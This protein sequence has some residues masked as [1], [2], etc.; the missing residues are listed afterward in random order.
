MHAQRPAPTPQDST[1][2][3]P[4]R[5][6]APHQLQQS[7][8][9]SCAPQRPLQP[10]RHCSLQHSRCL[11]SQPSSRSHSRA[12][13]SHCSLACRALAARSQSTRAPRRL[14]AECRHAGRLLPEGLQIEAPFQRQPRGCVVLTRMS[15]P[16][17]MMQRHLRLR[18]TSMEQPLCHSGGNPSGVA[19]R[20]SPWISAVGSLAS[21][22]TVLPGGS[23]VSRR[24]AAGRPNSSSDRDTV[25]SWLTPTTVTC[26][27]CLVRCQGSLLSTLLLQQQRQRGRCVAATA[28]AEPCR[29][30][31][32]GRGGCG[33]ASLGPQVP[34]HP[35]QLHL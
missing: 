4:Q 34:L 28:E 11:Q 6:S 24:P 10:Q 26:L 9:G 18:P 22:V 16:G 21:P 1:S 3:A 31:A 12:S 23:P 5:Q 25:V 27:L 33:E 35:P 20:R 7:Q 8:A 19:C 15:R 17:S 29:G 30:Q 13:N 2:Q 14:H 32:K